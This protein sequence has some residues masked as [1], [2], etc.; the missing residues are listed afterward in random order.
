MDWSPPSWRTRP[1][2]QQPDY[3]NA[4]EVEC[5]LEQVRELPPLVQIS[6]IDGLKA[7]IIACQNNEAFLLQVSDWG[8]DTNSLQGGDCAESF[9]NGSISS[10]QGQYKLLLQMSLLI[11]HFTR[12]PVVKV[13]RIAGQFAKPR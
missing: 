8:C 2:T 10:V 9:E 7:Q 6:D 11:S 4:E 3:A 12:K 13:G 5:V 1:I